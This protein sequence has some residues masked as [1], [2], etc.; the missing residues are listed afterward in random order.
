P[1]Y[2]RYSVLYSNQLLLDKYKKQV[3]ET[4]EEL[5]KTGRYIYE[6]EKENNNTLQYIY[7]GLFTG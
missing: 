5:I 3:P 7:N 4:W 2:Q 1:I 6:K